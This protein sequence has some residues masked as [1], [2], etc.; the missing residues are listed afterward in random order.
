M[1]QQL[2]GLPQISF[3][4]IDA[5]HAPCCEHHTIN[6]LAADDIDKE[7]AAMIKAVYDEKGMPVGDISAAIVEYYA[8]KLWDGV[9]EGYGGIDY[10][11]PDENMLN[12]LRTNVWQFSS[13]KNYQ[14]LVSLSKALV[15]EDGAL[16]SFR[17]FKEAAREINEKFVEQWLKAEYNLAVSGSQMASKWVNIEQNAGVL[18]YLVFDAIIDMQTTELCR[19]L[20]G[21]KLP[22]DH[23]F[24]K[25]Y[26]PP[27]HYGERSTVRQAANGPATAA[28]KIPSIEIPAMFRTNLAQQRL[29]FP[30][31]H[32]YFDGVPP[33]VLEQGIS[34][35]NKNG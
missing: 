23:P 7:L 35:M 27:N 16:R 29:I 18:P 32:P 13:A 8:N 4:E 17:A 5:L 10:A 11:T 14:Q 19:E 22:I 34:L 30:K 1:I 20:N 15:D 26:Y 12:A 33:N 28:G 6:N 9:T 24:W 2:S 21:T 31:S 3:A 25:I